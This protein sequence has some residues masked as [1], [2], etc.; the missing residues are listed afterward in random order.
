VTLMEHGLTP[1][2]IAARMVAIS[3]PEAPQAAL[4]AGLLAV[5][6]QFIGTIEDSARL[7]VEIADA[8]EGAQQRAQTIVKTY[9]EERRL[10]A[11]FGHH[12]HRPDDPRSPKLIAVA[13][14][15]GFGGRYIEALLTLASAVDAAAGR[16]ITINATGAIGAILLELGIPLAA[17]RGIAIVSRAAGLVGHI[18][19]ERERP[20]ARFIWDLAE[21][22]I[23]HRAG[24]KASKET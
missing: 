6:S 15:H 17:V 11:G 22:E 10:L 2:S 3:S 4:A 24:P 5:G 13:R 14:E 20:I 23:E 21:R 9:R 18:Q 16:H 8:P 12:L 1:S 7:L 19:E